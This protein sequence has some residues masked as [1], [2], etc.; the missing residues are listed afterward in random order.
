MYIESHQELARHPKTARLARSLSVSKVTAIGHLH[1]FWWWCLDYAPDGDL[2]KFTSAEIADGSMWDGDPD[3]F[4]QALTDGRFIDVFANGEGLAV[5]D[6]N[7]YG[8][9]LIEKRKAD[10]IRK[11]EERARTSPP[12]PADIQRTSSG[13][14]RDG[15]G[16]EEK[17]REEYKTPPLPPSG[18][19]DGEDDAE[20]SEVNGEVNIGEPS[21]FTSLATLFPNKG[22]RLTALREFKRLNPDLALQV[23]MARGLRWQMRQ[24]SWTKEDGR[25]VPRLARWI[26]NREWED[27]P[28]EVLE[29]SPPP[30]RV[31]TDREKYPDLYEM[32]DRDRLFREAREKNDWTEVNARYGGPNTAH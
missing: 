25:Y 4:I 1:C 10:A 24:E 26:K 3:A 29:N 8:G 28:A 21:A 15:A 7:Q 30:R 2:S 12:R 19:N 32:K 11:A 20:C 22:G 9:K 14:P 23:R 18:G 6:W 13:H 27:A 31:L 17:I 16:R 5:H